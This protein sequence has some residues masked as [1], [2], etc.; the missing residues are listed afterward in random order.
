MGLHDAATREQ[1]V[2]INF[3]FSLMTAKELSDR[4]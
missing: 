1:A 3:K 4:Y 2:I